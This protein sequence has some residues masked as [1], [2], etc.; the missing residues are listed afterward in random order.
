VGEQPSSRI[1]GGRELVGPGAFR[2]IPWPS[3]QD[4]YEHDTMRILHICST[5]PL[6]MKAGTQGNEKRRWQDP[7]RGGRQEVP[8]TQPTV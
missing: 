4:R 2:V 5:Q 6:A 8:L 1:K 7:G 3:S